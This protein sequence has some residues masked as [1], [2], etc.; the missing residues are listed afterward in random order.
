MKLL[1]LILDR[2]GQNMKKEKLHLDLKKEAFR[3]IEGMHRHKVLL[4]VSMMGSALIFFFMTIAFTVSVPE[5]SRGG[6]FEFP[7]AFVLSTI[8]LLLSSFGVSKVL[9]AFEEGNV[10]TVKKW[11]GATLF[12]GLVFAASQILG[13]Q[14]LKN[15][16]LLLSGQD[17]VAYLYVISGLHVAHMTGLLGFLLWLLMKCHKATK[18]P[19]NRLVYETNSYQKVRFEMLTDAWHFIDVL[20]LLLFCY[21]FF[22]F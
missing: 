17:S 1:R 22:I 15:E 10:E 4:Y 6:A 16:E 8:L 11:L 7:K 3:K 18:D 14:A 13:W 9:P 21:F 19:V 20:W 5:S 2:H 12:L